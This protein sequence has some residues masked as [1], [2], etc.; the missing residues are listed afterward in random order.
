MTDKQKL[1]DMVDNLIDGK[2]EQAQT[3]FHQYV[4]DKV[5]N[6][7]SKP[8]EEPAQDIDTGNNQE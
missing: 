1:K 4:K 3:M 8:S 5:Q 7:F 6:V 2:P